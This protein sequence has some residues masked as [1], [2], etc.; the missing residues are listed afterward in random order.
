MFIVY[1]LCGLCEEA[2]QLGHPVWR[3][4]DEHWTWPEAVQAAQSLKL[5]IGK[6]C[7]VGDEAGNLLYLC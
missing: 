1:Y 3:Q 4:A 6:P 2:Q 5:R 7:A